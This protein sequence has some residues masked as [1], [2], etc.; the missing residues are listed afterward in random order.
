MNDQPLSPAPPATSASI[1]AHVESYD[2]K[3]PSDDLGNYGNAIIEKLLS[4]KE[5]RQ[6]ASLYAEERHFRSHIHMARHGFGKGEYRY[7]RYPLPDLI[8]ALRT[9]LY[10]HLAAV[11]NGWNTRLGIEQRFPPAHADYLAMCH[12]DGQTRPTPSLLQYVPGDYNCLH[13]DLYGD[14]VF[15]YRSRS[16]S[17][18]RVRISRAENSSWPSNA[19]ACKAGPRWCRSARAA[20]WRLPSIAVPFKALRA[21]IGSIFAMGSAACD[22]ECV[23]PSESFHDAR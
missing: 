18:S 7:F 10:P 16:C 21:L 9:A 2:W 17:R 11:A 19:R 6:I 12:D 13:Q 5:C 15:R 4:P 3:L 14:L 1:N 20:R 23:I 8:G 22:R